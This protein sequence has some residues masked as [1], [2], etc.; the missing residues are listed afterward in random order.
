MLRRSLIWQYKQD[1]QAIA[2]AAD[3]EIAATEIIDP[4][5]GTSE[6]ASLEA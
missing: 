5:A 1:R 2:E 4:L 3:T 6:A